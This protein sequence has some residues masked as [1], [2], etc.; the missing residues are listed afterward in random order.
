[1]SSEMQSFRLLTSSPTKRS[2]PRPALRRAESVFAALAP[3][4]LDR[5]LLGHGFPTILPPRLDQAGRQL[6]PENLPVHYCADCHADA[7]AAAA[8]P[9][10]RLFSN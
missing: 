10:K 1:M 9:L 7:L 8:A 4:E 6:Q 5:L 2:T 3:H